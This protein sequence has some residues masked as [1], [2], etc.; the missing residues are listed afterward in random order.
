MTIV[1]NE[2]LRFQCTAIGNP[3]PKIKWI[4]DGKTVGVGD[5]LT[6]GA[7]RSHSGIYW[8][9]A[10]NGLNFIANASA[11]LN[12]QC[13]YGSITV[14]HWKSKETSHSLF[15]GGGGLLYGRDGDAC[16]KV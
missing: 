8:C 1:E 15:P 9:L 11:Y 10:E 13:K 3:V 5:T 7:L 4:K 6:F 14:S 16:Q 2:I 12:V